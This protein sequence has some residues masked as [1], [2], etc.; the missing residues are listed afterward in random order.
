MAK[1]SWWQF[2]KTDVGFWLLVGLNIISALFLA[3]AIL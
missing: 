3:S 1:R 2:V